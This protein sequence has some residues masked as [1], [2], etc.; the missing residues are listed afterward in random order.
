MSEVNLFE[1]EVTKDAGDPDGYHASCARIAPLVG[2]R[3]LGLSVYELPSGQSIPP[4]ISLPIWAMSAA[5]PSAF[6]LPS[7]SAV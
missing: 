4:L 7:T 1:V 3:L 6:K 2:G 5:A